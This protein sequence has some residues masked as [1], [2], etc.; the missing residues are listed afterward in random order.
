MTSAEATSKNLDEWLPNLGKKFIFV[1]GTTTNATDYITV[2][3]L[4]IVQGFY[5]VS[6]GGTIAAGT[7][8][9]TTNVITLSNG[10]AGTKIWSGFCWGY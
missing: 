8:A 6:T 3:G 4:T 9:T 7:C 2:T 10:A 1:E 5:L